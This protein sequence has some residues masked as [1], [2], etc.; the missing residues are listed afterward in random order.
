[1]KKVNAIILILLTALAAR[2]TAQS[3]PAKDLYAGKCAV[4][5]AADGSANTSVGKS[6]KIP[7]FHSV[8]VQNQSDAD[9]KTMITKGKGAMPT[10]A[11]KLTDAQIDQMVTYIRG[12]GKK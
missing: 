5:H 2:A 6:L 7:N 12:L 3:S 11:G 8:D 9:L 10:F 4:C 1:M